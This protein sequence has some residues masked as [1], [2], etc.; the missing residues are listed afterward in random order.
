MSFKRGPAR[1]GQRRSGRY[2]IKSGQ[3]YR[4]PYRKTRRSGKRTSKGRTLRRIGIGLGVAGGALLAVNAGI[5]GLAGT[6]RAVKELS[7][8]AHTIQKWAK[9]RAVRRT[10][11]KASSLAFHATRVKRLKVYKPRRIKLRKFIKR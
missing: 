7:G 5:L 1:S 6:S 11:L 8:T 10:A 3:S 2:R 4:P 9:K